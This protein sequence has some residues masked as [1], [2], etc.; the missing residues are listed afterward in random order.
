[1]P[2]IE[3]S[4]RARRVIAVVL[5]SLALV[6]LVYVVGVFTALRWGALAALTEDSRDA[7]VE[8]QGGHSFWPNRIVLK[9]AR[10]RFKDYNIEVMI[11]VREATIHWS[12][13]ALFS[14]RIQIDEFVAKGAR[15]KMLHRVKHRYPNR[16]RLAAFPDTGFSRSK[17]YDSPKPAY[18]APPFRIQVRNIRASVEEAWILEY[19]AMGHMEATGGFDLSADVVVLPGHVAFRR[20]RILVGDKTLAS[21]VD[22]DLHARIGPFPGREPLDAALAVTDGRV[23]D[24]HMALADLS[25]L[26]VY[27]PDSPVV[28]EGKAELVAKVDL[29]RG[30]A[31]S[32]ELR[33][34]AQ[35]E[36]LGLEHAF[37]SGDARVVGKV[38]DTGQIRTIGSFS[39][40]PAPRGPLELR[41]AEV[42]LAAEQPK[43]V[44]TKM[45]GVELKL[46]SLNVRDP[47]LLRQL[48][49]AEKAPLLK[50]GRADLDLSYVV[51]TGEKPGRFELQS[52]GALAWFPKPEV[53]I[54]CEH[55]AS[56]RC[57]L[58]GDGASCPGSAVACAPVTVEFPGERSATIR[59]SLETVTLE[60]SQERTTSEWKVS[61][62]NPKAMLQAALPDNAWTDLGLA[63]APLGDV[64]GRGR[65]NLRKRTIAGTV[66]DVR[67]G[68]F[69]AQGGFMLA[70]SLVSRWRV[71]TP[72]GRFG[73]TQ[74]P[75][76]TNIRPF[77]GGDWDVLAFED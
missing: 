33:V 45:T 55:R 11:E 51:Q 47:T 37:V 63:L 7:H 42:E 32:S 1:M 25:A 67:S 62:G 38:A 50:V 29:V 20:A 44:D 21:R 64:E 61:L 70:T 41:L 53:A 14:K 30:Q 56:V 35:L 76:G 27:F 52:Q 28:L 69:A 39:G 26:G 34:D 13:L 57:Q 3:V 16:E 40:N 59:A 58:L 10:F 8:A 54:S 75:S 18:H 6:Y 65:V 77:V 4:S 23:V 48:G 49:E 17:I 68:A 5:A 66:D 22:C 71:T 74:T 15:Y 19:R 43:L 36:R 2:T 9:N 72:L 46:G 24:C 31:R 60:F 12:P 73:V